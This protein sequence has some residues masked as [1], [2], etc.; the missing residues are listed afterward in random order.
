M[1]LQA[2]GAISMSQINT[3]LGTN[4]NHLDDSWIRLLAAKPSGIIK[5]SDLYS[6]TGH[7][8]GNILMSAVPA[9]VSGISGQLWFN[10]MFTELLKNGVNQAELRFNSGPSWTSTIFVLN[11]STGASTTLAAQNSVS[12]VGTNTANLLRASQNDNFTI[13]PI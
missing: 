10:D 12:W 2:S 1:T 4:R 5:F 9:S 6:K 13:R 11:N 3:E 7:F 8:T